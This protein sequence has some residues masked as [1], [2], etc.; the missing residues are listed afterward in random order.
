[1]INLGNN[2]YKKLLQV[3]SELDMKPEHLLNV[4][5]IESGINPQSQNKNGGAIGLVQFM[6]D[7][8]HGLGFKGS[9]AEFKEIGAENQL[10]YVKKWIQGLIKTNGGPLKSAAQYYVGNFLP[11]ALTLPG[12][13]QE[14]PNTIIVAKNPKKPHLPGVSIKR[15][16]SYYNANPYLDYNK[17]GFITYEDIQNILKRS[18][19]GKNYQGVIA[20]LQ[21]STGYSPK[22]LLNN[23]PANDN[24][25][26]MLDS[27]LKNIAASNKKIYNKYLPNNNILIKLESNNYVNSIEFARIICAALDEEL[28]SK[29][30]THISNENDIEIECKIA[31]TPDLCFNTV[32]QLTESIHDIFSNIIDD[33]INISFIKDKKSYFNQIDAKYAEMQYR[34]FLLNKLGQI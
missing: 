20:E 34:K 14:I 31:G 18:A 17:D 6:P 16:Q 30:S 23:V 4:M 27:F 29:S 22:N 19:S 12:V 26:D 15:E 13:K 8:L 3:S 5:D 33:K 28:L 2:F 24:L 25:D 11:V 10:D 21:K 32:K 1:M 9:S 7:T